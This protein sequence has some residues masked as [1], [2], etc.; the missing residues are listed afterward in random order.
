MDAKLWD[1]LDL[2]SFS[3]AVRRLEPSLSDVMCKNLFTRIQNRE[4]KVEM[5]TL[6]QNFCGTEHE[7][8]D[9]KQKMFKQ[10][11]SEIFQNKKQREFL[12]LCEA[13]D[14]LNDGKIEPKKL[15]QVL[16]TITAGSSQPCSEEAIQ[17]FVK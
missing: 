10:L 6:L 13:E 9:Y 4:Q 1:V 16:K 7:T 3:A 2:K 11:Y 12:S 17:K 15:E 5:Q 14:K 8:V